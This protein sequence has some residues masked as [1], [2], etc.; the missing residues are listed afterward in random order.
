[1]SNV[2]LSK[3]L[4]NQFV[5]FYNAIYTIYITVTIWL[6][7]ETRLLSNFPSEQYRTLGTIKNKNIK[8]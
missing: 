7:K 8:R 3:Q 2:Q 6:S 5:L 4:R 1:M